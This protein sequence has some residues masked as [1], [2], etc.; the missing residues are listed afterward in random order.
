MEGRI[1]SDGILLVAGPKL[2]VV[3]D[4]PVLADLV[5]TAPQTPGVQMAHADAPAMVG[6]GGLARRDGAEAAGAGTAGRTPPLSPSSADSRATAPGLLSGSLW[7]PHLGLCTHEG[8]PD[9]QGHSMRRVAR[10]S[11]ALEDS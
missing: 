6:A 11:E 9:S 8:Q 7:L 3:Q 5:R 4:G 1:L 2:A 10:P